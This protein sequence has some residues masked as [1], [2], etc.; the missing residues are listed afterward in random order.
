M[1]V[2]RLP[3]GDA[4]VELLREGEGDGRLAERR[5]VVG[6]DQARVRAEARVLLPRVGGSRTGRPRA[7][8]V[9]PARSAVVTIIAACSNRS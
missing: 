7:S 1:R 4:P 6:W 5:A 2:A 9:N 3:G 8:W